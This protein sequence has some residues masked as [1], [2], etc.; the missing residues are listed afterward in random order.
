MQDGT[1]AGAK[2]S[3]AFGDGRARDGRLLRVNCRMDGSRLM[4]R[5]ESLIGPC[6][7]VLG[8]RDRAASGPPSTTARPNPSHS[9]LRDGTCCPVWVSK[10]MGPSDSHSHGMPMTDHGTSRR[11][12]PRIPR[13]TCASSLAHISADL[14]ALADAGELGCRFIRA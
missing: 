3:K 5:G 9:R 1:A 8:G 12:A 10:S 4:D 2:R 14:V 6:G 11:Q 7:G 13:F